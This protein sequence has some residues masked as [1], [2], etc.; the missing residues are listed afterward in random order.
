MKGAKGNDRIAAM[1]AAPGMPHLGGTLAAVLFL[2]WPA[3]IEQIMLTLVQYVDTAMVGSLGSNATAAVGLTSSTTWLFN[4]FFNAAAIGFSVQVAQHLGAG[5]Q[6]DAKRVTWQALRFVG[7]FGVMMGAIAFALSFYL[8]AMLGADPAIRGDASLYFRIMACA[9][10]FTL[11]SNMLS[12]VI[13][14]AGDTR[15]PMLLNL[16]INVLNVILNTVFIYAPRTVTLFGREVFVWGAGWGVRGAAFA[17]ALSTAFVAC[18]FLMVVFRK[19]SPIQISFKKRYRFERPCLMAAWR[20]GLPAALERS[21][22][23]VAQIVITALITGIGTVAVAANHLAVTAESISYLPASGVAVAGT[24][25][26]G[27]AIGAGRK[28]LAKRFGRMVSWMGVA[29]M[30]FGG[31]V[32]FLF[33]EPLIRIFSTDLEVIA[34]GSQV[35]RIVAFAEPLFGA[36]IVAS[37]ALRGAGDSKGPFLINLAT[38]WG[39]RITLSLVLVG[40]LGLIGVWLAMAAELCARGLIFMIRLY[41]GKWLHIDLFQDRTKAAKNS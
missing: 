17:S 25:L 2:A 35:L 39:V 3:I 33:S 38:M 16:M 30:T 26:V 31:G 6:E 23:C 24:T 34:L 29:I 10:P 36:S 40:S 11:G 8:P 18:M 37:G 28:D 27:Q 41:R 1:L 19:K 20:L 9:M 21:T 4:G 32:L 12:A 22:L 14:C 7:I 15:T 5:R 13:R